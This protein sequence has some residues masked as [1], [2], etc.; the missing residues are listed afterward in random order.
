[1]ARMVKNPEAPTMLSA[2]R[3]TKVEGGKVELEMAKLYY[4]DI[5]GVDRDV[6]TGKAANEDYYAPERMLVPIAELNRL[7]A[8]GI[9]RDVRR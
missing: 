5:R 3:V 4:T 9:V 8:D 6:N 7:Y 1:M 2:L